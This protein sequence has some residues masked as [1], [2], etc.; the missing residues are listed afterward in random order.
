LSMLRRVA[1]LL[2]A[3]V[4]VVFE[5]DD[6]PPGSRLGVSPSHYRRKRRLAKSS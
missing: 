3:H 4:R 2:R 6:T 1:K 5:P